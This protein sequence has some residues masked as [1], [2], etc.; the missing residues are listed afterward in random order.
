MAFGL[1][2]EP[3]TRTSGLVYKAGRRL[4][5][6]YI[7]APEI[8]GSKCLACGNDLTSMISV[9]A[10]D[11]LV[12]EFPGYPLVELELASWRIMKPCGCR[13]RICSQIFSQGR[14]W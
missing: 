14:N 13:L 4:R 5:G 10:P 1:N 2:Q 3:T 11:L 12:L 7:G 8:H 9:P 6:K